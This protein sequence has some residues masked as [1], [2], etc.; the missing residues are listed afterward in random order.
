MRGKSKFWLYSFVIK[1]SLECTA[2][3][4]AVQMLAELQNLQCHNVHI[5][6]ADV[7][8]MNDF[9]NL[10]QSRILERREFYRTHKGGVTLS[11]TAPRDL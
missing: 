1:P 7:H 9:C 11:T 5:L 4:G 3:G 8:S 2:I 10:S 6:H